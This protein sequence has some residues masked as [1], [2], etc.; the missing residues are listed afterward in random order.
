MAGTTVNLQSHSRV[1]ISEM[2]LESWK[3]IAA[4]L[5][6][7]VRTVRR[8]ERLERMPVHRHTHNSQATVYAFRSELDAWLE[9][10]SQAG[11]KK[12]EE[13]DKPRAWWPRLWLLLGLALLLVILYGL[14]FGNWVF[15]I[16]L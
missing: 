4:H 13:A 2:R 16:R 12:H 1:P 11:R 8:W 7:S 10:R 14:L 3:E 9:K 6:R 5:K 15:V